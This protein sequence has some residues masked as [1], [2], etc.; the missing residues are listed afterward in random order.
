MVE[1]E[2]VFGDEFRRTLSD[3][4]QTPLFTDIERFVNDEVR[5]RLLRF[6]SALAAMNEEINLTAI[7]EPAEMAVKHVADSLLA[8][9][10]GEWPTEARVCDVGTG[11][12]VP[13]VVL[14]I[15]RPDLQVTLL[16]SVRKKLRAV[17]SISETIGVSVETVHGRAEDVG[18]APAYREQ[19]DVVTARAVARLPVL[20]ELCLPLTKVDGYMVALKGPDVREE[21]EQSK[22]AL[23]L[24]GAK[25]ETVREVTLPF[26]AGGRTLIAIRKVASTPQKYPRSAG[27]PAKNPL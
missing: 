3:C 25:I 7:T 22:A 13:G 24:L 19:F 8:L 26:D 10:V 6:S 23:R 2:R 9:T 18:R 21:I 12:G 16:D 11:G 27:T 1:N 14:R 5:E 15:A 17:M 4:L 20:L